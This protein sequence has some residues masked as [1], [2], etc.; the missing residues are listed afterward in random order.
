M[1]EDELL[2]ED[3]GKILGEQTESNGIQRFIIPK[4]NTPNKILIY[5]VLTTSALT[6]LFAGLFIKLY[7]ETKKRNKK[8]D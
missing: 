4:N 2:D 8:Q 7:S 3:T 5:F 6:I 1:N